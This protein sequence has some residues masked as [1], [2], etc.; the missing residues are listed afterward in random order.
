ME[1]INQQDI[2]KRIS[3]DRNGFVFFWNKKVLRAIYPARE[4]YV[5]ELFDCG[6]IDDLVRHRLFPTT[7]RTEYT[8]EQS[9][10][11]LEHERISPVLAPENWSFEMLKDACLCLL[12]VNEIASKY[13]YSTIDAHG[14]NILFHHNEPMFVDLGSFI[15]SETVKPGKLKGW[16]ALREF[17]DMMYVPLKL[18]SKNWVWFPG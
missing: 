9:S 6:L 12:K 7:T 14:Y 8:I 17:V 11:V 4:Q 13:G 18:K 1:T 2:I 3:V 10:M 15:K 5:Q 16:R